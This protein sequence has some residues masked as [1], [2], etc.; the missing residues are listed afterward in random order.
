[1]NNKNKMIGYHY[2]N[3]KAYQS[4]HTNGVDRNFRTPFND[5]RGLIPSKMFVHPNLKG[6][7]NEAYNKV[8]ESLLESEPNSWLENSEFPHLWKLLMHDICR[9]EETILLSF[10]LEPKDKAYVVDRAHVERELRKGPIAGSL[11]RAYKKY[12][13][14]KVPFFEYDDSYSA[15]QLVIWSPIEFERLNV[16]WTKSTEEVW[17]RVLDNNW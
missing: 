17:Q 14:S 6:F 11:N 1:M 8:V 3:Q 7:P 16:E 2:T 5:F 10:E 12:W 9:E 15:P 13:E 4:M